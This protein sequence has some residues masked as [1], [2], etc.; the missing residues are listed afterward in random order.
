[1][2]K[3]V[4]ITGAS[5]NLGRATV[6]Q[7]LSEGYKVIITTSPGKKHGFES[8]YDLIPYE[9]DLTNEAQTTETVQRIYE[10]NKSIDAAVM[11]VGGWAGGGIAETDGGLIKKMFALN[12]DTAYFIARPIFKIMQ[13]NKIP[14]RLVFVGS[15]PALFPNE[16]KNN[17]A[18]GLSKSLLFKLSEYLNAEGA[19]NN[20]VSS[21]IVPGTID[22]PDNRKTMPKANFNKWVAPEEIAR[23]ISFVCNADNQA[24]REPVLKFFGK[25]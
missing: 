17:L 22:T 24:L 4:L 16:G 6:D 5:G 2:K 8:H 13:D 25:D 21:V 1:M 15:R 20:I 12:F 11:L 14:G 7:F 23:G 18:Y 9:V 19:V 3:N 10:E